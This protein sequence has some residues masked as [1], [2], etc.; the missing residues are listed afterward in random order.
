MRGPVPPMWVLVAS[1]ALGAQANDTIDFPVREKSLALA[2]QA[3][4]SHSLPLLAAPQLPSLGDAKRI[5]SRAGCELPGT[6]VC[7]DAAERRIGFVGARRYM[8]EIG[9][10]TSEGISVSRHRVLFK[11]SW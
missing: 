9:G 6:I 5:G 11:Y 3:E 10:M 1:V 4:A 2:V 7:Y 8:P